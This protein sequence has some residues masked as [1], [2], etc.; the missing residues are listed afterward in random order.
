[1]T[2]SHSLMTPIIK[3]IPIKNSLSFPNEKNESIS[4]I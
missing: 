4:I 2:S 1:M 3:G